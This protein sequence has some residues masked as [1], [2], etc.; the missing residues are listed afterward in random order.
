MSN[1]RSND[2]RTARQS[3]FVAL[4]HRDFRLIWLGQIISGAGTQMQFVAINYHIYELTG[5][6]VA[7]GLIGLVRVIPIVIFALIGGVVADA[8]DRRKLMLTT[9]IVMMGVAASLGFLTT[10]GQI[11]PWAI[12]ALTSVGAAAVAFDSP[13][14]QSIM[15]NLVPR[16]HFANAVSLGTIA[17]QGANIVGPSLAGVVIERL[18]IGMAYWLNAASFIAVLTALLL[19][20]TQLKANEQR[21]VSLSAFR[22]GIRFVFGQPLIRVTMLLDFVATFFGA[23]NQLLPIFAKDILGIGAQGLGLLSSA[24]AVGAVSASAVMSFI[25]RLRRQGPLLLIA[26][27]LYGLATTIFGL[28]RAF[29]LSFL[30]LALVGGADI[31]STVIRQTIRQLVTPDRLRGRMVSVNMIFFMGG[32]QLGELE[33][34]LLAAVVGAPASVAIGGAACLGIVLWV[35]LTNRLLRAYDDEPVSVTHS[36]MVNSPS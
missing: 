32:P 28:S 33:A 4:Q 16:R 24:S 8:V 14:R 25:P 21:D 27:V 10:S 26:V 12:Y 35:A 19:I 17:W 11:T 36:Q 3:P 2:A 30:A 34:G 29:W 20:R 18:G 9:Q 15:P 5:S 1:L 13:A 31:V 7:L 23:A 6:P 22:E